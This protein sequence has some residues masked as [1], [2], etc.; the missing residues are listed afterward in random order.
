MKIRL[1]K[2]T[3]DPEMSTFAY[4]SCKTCVQL[5]SCRSDARVVLKASFR[6][7]AQGRPLAN[8]VSILQER[9]TS[10]KIE[11]ARTTHRRL[12]SRYASI[13]EVSGGGSR[14]A[15]YRDDLLGTMEEDLIDYLW[16]GG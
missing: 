12:A 16:S 1:H 7:S 13:L 14:G 2:A 10:M 3:E 5:I 11:M 4:A 8:A 15:K 6:R 9:A